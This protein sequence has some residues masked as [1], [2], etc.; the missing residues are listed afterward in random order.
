MFHDAEYVKWANENTIHAMSYSLDKDAKKP[1]PM[2]NVSRDDGTVEALAAFP[3]FTANEAEALVNE[4][5]SA[6]TF[7]TSTPWSGVISPVDGKT[8]LAEMKNGTAKEFRALYDAEQKKLGASVPRALWKKV[9][10]DLSAST[11]AEFD[12]KFADAV[13]R[14]LEAGTLVKDPPKPLLERIEARKAGMEKIGR[15]RLAAALKEKDPAKRAKAIAA[16]ATDWKGL[17]AGKAAEEA[18]TAK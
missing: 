3:M 1:E 4:I 13:K 14:V 17:P 16:V 9:V 10:A 6:V 15:D 12:E 7:P 18:A 5:N 8:V 2:I 11:E